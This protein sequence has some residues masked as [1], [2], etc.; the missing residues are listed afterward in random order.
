[1]SPDGGWSLA[2][3]DSATL[4]WQGQART[5]VQLET[6]AP[7]HSRR[8]PITGDYQP[9]QR[10]LDAYV[11]NLLDQG[12]Y[13]PDGQILEEDYESGSFLQSKMYHEG[14]TCSDCHDPHS[15]K[16]KLATF[17]QTCSGCHSPSRFDTAAH[18]HHQPDT[19]GAQCVSCHM[20]TRTYMVIDVRR[21]HSFRVPRPDLSSRYGTPNACNQCHQDRTAGW[22]ADAVAKWFGP[23]PAQKPH[24]VEAIDAGRRGSAGAE[25]LLTA[26]VLN[27]AQPAIARATALTLLRDYLSPAS[28]GAVRAAMADS[29]PLVRAAALRAM[30]PLP[31]EDRAR[32][33]AAMLSDPLRSV[34]IEAARLL[35]GTPPS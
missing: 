29:D 23:G 22:A 5:R 18:H 13:F 15:G 11:P 8:R 3:P 27:S 31:P 10:F 9:G 35:A 4:H 26:L 24:F 7:C 6:C 17:N 14:V 33:G 19:P 1:R 20:P 16:L 32:L 34:R 25:A 28:L 21:D 12:V 2:D 30:E